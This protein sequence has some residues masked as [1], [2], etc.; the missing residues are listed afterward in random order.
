LGKNGKALKRYAKEKMT[1]LVIKAFIPAA[2]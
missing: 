2:L 1:N